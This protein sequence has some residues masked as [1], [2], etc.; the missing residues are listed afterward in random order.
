MRILN[1]L[2][3]IIIWIGLTNLVR[4]TTFL[5][6]S[7]FYELKAHLRNKKNIPNLLYC[8][9]FSVIIPAHNEGTTILRAVES[10]VKNSYPQNKV[11][12]VVVDDGS[13]DNTV[14]IIEKYKQENNIMNLTIVTQ[15]NAGKANA[16]NN[17]IKN[18][19]IGELVMCLDA[20]SYMEKHALRNAS[21]YFLNESVATMSANVKIIKQK[22]FLNVIQ[23]FEYIICY[24][25]KRAQTLLGVEYIIGGIGSTFRRSVLELVDYY[26]TNSQTED[27]DLT[28]KIIRNGNK[29]YK[30]IYGS[31]VVANTEACLSVKDLCRQRFRWKNGR[32]QTF[33]KNRD[34]F[35]N[36]N[37]KYTKLLTMFY[38]PYALYGDIA[39]FLEPLIV[40]YLLYIIVRYT[41]LITLGM[42]FLVISVYISINVL[43]ENTMKLKDRIKM[44]LIAPSMW[45]FFYI[46]SYAEYFALIKSYA[47]I[48]KVLGNTN[49]DCKWTHV[50]RSS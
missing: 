16:L 37:K 3:Y 31:N 25:M 38:L 26:D 49:N 21:Q 43:A 20:D 19:S 4:M 2:D 50:E 28:F 9:T 5:V 13:V 42:S 24:Q 30:A 48:H 40:A 29:K 35:F 47:T 6:A 11:E 17:G 45:L 10:I 44:L 46:L 18:H 15:T 7:D 32:T 1:P 36:P 23:Q 41:D 39:F 33:Y 34:M 8:P 14:A 12:I 22:N 27:I